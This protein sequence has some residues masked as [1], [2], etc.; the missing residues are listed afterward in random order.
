MP[1]FR[2]F[3]VVLQD[4]QNGTKTKRDVISRLCELSL[5]KAVVAEEQYN[6]QEGSHIHI[7]YRLTSQ[8]HFSAQLKYWMKWWDHG[9]VQVDQMYGEMHQCCKYLMPHEGGKD[10]DHDPD[11]WFYPTRLIAVS[12][13]QHADEWFHWFVSM[14][15]AE[16]REISRAYCERVVHAYTNYRQTVSLVE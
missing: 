16:Y 2:G 7:F 4:V 9:R 3:S 6:H 5:E 10:K 13:Q 11:P 14:P 12:P 1:K 8:V 15:I